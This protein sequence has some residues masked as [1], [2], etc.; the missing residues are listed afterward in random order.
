MVP[1]WVEQ[2][3]ASETCSKAQLRGNFHGDGALVCRKNVQ[4]LYFYNLN[5]SYSNAR[6]SIPI[7][8][9]KVISSI[10]TLVEKRATSRISVNYNFVGRNIMRV[11]EVG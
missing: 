3:Y 8:P 2:A 1:L 6:L 5:P 4:R 9:S 7:L 10:P 11:R